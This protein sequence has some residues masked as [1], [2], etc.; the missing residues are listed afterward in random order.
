MRRTTGALSGLLIVILGAWGALI[1]FVG[2]YFNFGFTPDTAWHWT[3]SRLVLDVLPGVAA[4]VG[5]LMLMGSIRRGSAWVGG[6]IALWAG[7]W[8]VVGPSVSMLWNSGVP[9]VS[10]PLGG[11]LRRTL[12]WLAFF[13]G[14]GAAIIALAGLALGRLVPYRRRVTAADEAAAVEGGP[15]GRRRRAAVAAGDAPAADAPRSE[16]PA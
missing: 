1:P 12:E 8:F 4:V 15:A 7:V 5:G 16:P 9:D 10:R 13:Y 6:W 14:I 2:P 11:D 3:T